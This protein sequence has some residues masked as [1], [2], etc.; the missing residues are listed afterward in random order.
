MGLREIMLGIFLAVSA[1]IDMKYKE[2]SVKVLLFFGSVGVLFFMIGRPVSWQEEIGGVL[3]GAVILL[4]YKVTR[5][6]IGSGDGYLLMVTGL[7]LG[8]SRNVELLL[9]GL[10]LAAVWSAVLLALKKV[11]RKHEIPFVPFLFLSFAGMVIL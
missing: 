3:I 8:L 7:F 1:V 6:E 5:G 11:S 4:L 2:V 10:L 9:G